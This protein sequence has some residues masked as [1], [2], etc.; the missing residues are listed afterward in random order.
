MG[1]TFGYHYDKAH[2]LVGLINQI[3]YAETVL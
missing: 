1:H 2:R 3:R